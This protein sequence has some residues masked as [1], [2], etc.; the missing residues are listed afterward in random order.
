MKKT[1]T[2]LPAGGHA[3]VETIEGGPNIIG[4]LASMGLA[5]GAKVTI[6]QNFPKSPLIINVR[7]TFIALSRYEAGRI[8]VER[9]KSE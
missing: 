6:V 5:P 4:R 3:W 1:L 9:K 8:Y 7:Y 2:E